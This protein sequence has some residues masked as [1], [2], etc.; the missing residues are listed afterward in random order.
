[1][2]IAAPSEVEATEVGQ[3]GENDQPRNRDWRVVPNRY[4]EICEWGY[5]LPNRQSLEWRRTYSLVYNDSEALRDD[6]TVYPVS[7]R[8]QGIIKTLDV[9]VFGTWNGCVEFH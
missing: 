5:L 7:V 2:P 3:D 6:G 1:M 8:L 4:E 9:G